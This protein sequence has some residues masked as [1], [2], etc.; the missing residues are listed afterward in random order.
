LDGL[1]IDLYLLHAP[2]PRTP[3]RTSVRALARLLDEGMVRRIGVS[4]VNRSQIDEAVEIAGIS[5]VEDALS[6]RDDRAIRGGVVDRCAE[7]NRAF[8][9]AQPARPARRPALQQGSDV[10][11]IMGIPGAGKSRHAEEHVAR[12]YVRLNRDERGGSLRDI[13]RALDEQL[14]AGVR[15]LVL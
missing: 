1:A 8:G 11:L 13:A 4:N 9:K 7:L 6:V 15:R 10:V 12:G 5:A 2:D 3:W 14:A